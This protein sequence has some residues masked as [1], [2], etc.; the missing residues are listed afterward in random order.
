MWGAQIDQ[1]KSP[2]N[3]K[4]WSLLTESAFYGLVTFD[5]A[6]TLILRFYGW[7]TLLIMRKDYPASLLPFDASI[8]TRT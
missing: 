5:M 4:T 3:R 6:I 1:C 7:N 8:K 2:V